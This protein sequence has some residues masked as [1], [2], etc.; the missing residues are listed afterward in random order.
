MRCSAVNLRYH[1]ELWNYLFR[2]IYNI[3]HYTDRKK[4]IHSY[5]LMV[6]AERVETKVSRLS[7]YRHVPLQGAK[8]RNVCTDRGFESSGSICHAIYQSRTTCQVYFPPDIQK[9]EAMKAFSHRTCPSPGS[10]VEDRS[11]LCSQHH[12]FFFFLAFASSYASRSIL[13]SAIIFCDQSR[14]D[15]T[16]SDIFSRSS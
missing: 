4:M 6:V 7:S 3:P 12:C 9:R 13:P 8:F 11:F 10:M 14:K 5:Q 16:V 15:S 1:W 2:K